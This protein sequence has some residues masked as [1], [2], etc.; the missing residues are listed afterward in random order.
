MPRESIQF[1]DEHAMARVLNRSRGTVPEVI[2]RLAWDLGLS[3]DEICQLK[4]SSISFEEKA[5]ILP[6]RRIPLEAEICRCLLNRR[7][8]YAGESEY[9]VI[10]DRLHRQMYPESVSRIARTALDTESLL[11]NIRL[12]DLRYGF[13]LRQIKEHG[14]PYASRVSG[15]QAPTMRAIFLPALKSA[16]HEAAVKIGPSPVSSSDQQR[17]Q[18]II[19]NEGASAAGL[20]LRMKL[21]LDIAAQESVALTWDQIDFDAALIRLADRSIPMTDDLKRHLLA[22]Y[23]SRTPDTD[24]HVLLRPRSMQPYDRF[25]I[26]R[27]IH[28]ALV[29]G[30]ADATLQELLNR[31]MRESEDSAI[32]R[33]M[34][35]R[36]SITWRE[37]AGLFQMEK[38]QVNRRLCRLMKEKKLVRIGTRYYLYGTVVSPEDQYDVIR[39][40]LKAVGTAFRKDLADLLKIEVRPC[41][42]ILHNLVEQGKLIKTGQ[43][44]SLPPKQEGE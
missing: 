25:G 6:D 19:K 43:H 14:W 5:A 21:E 17:L 38:G 37:A 15:I 36:G 18:E 16:G 24:P 2:L 22:L 10:S 12:I 1:P 34:E 20:A 11:A 33:Y 30:G 3:R 26:S 31:Q 13:I 4:W 40:Y 42:W 9:V 28:T 23:Y 27:A 44:Y 8:K 7:E 39:S 41:G 35:K 32:L 29:R